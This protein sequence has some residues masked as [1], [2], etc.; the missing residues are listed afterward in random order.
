MGNEIIVVT[1][2]P[3]SGTSLLMQLLEKAG[4]TIAS[5][6]IRH[7][8]INNPEGYYEL[9]S[10]KG[11]IKDNNFLSQL[12]GK[13]VKIVA[14]LPIYV[15]PSL[16]YKFIFMNRDIEEVLRSQEKM[17]AVDQRAKRQQLTEIYKNHIEKTKLFIEN[18]HFPLI[19]IYYK[20]L[21]FEPKQE[22][23]RLLTFLN[24]QADI[25]TLAS[26]IKPDLYRNRSK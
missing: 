7:A 22:I 21:L 18:N 8:D 14:P 15:D 12:N 26:Q 6:Q 23:Q 3:R 5:D 16:H 11:I 19:D 2:I 25:N 10:V 17:L 13:C 1:G 4:F 24:S 9:I 20:N